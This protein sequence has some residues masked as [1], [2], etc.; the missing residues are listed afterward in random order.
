[1][2]DAFDGGSFGEAISTVSADVWWVNSDKQIVLYGN[3]VS[4]RIGP[5][6]VSV[7]EVPRLE[8]LYQ[9]GEAFTLK[10]GHSRTGAC[11]T[12]DHGLIC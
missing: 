4:L 8:L 7:M 11:E 2:S 5:K 1:M 9:G 12:E 6:T 3:H 10:R